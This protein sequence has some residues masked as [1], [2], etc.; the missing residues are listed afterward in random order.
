MRTKIISIVNHKGGVGKTTTAA[1]LG[2]GLVKY[3]KKVL[4][5]DMDPQAGLTTS[6]KINTVSENNSY[7]FF[8][9]KKEI[10]DCIQETEIKNLFI[11]PSTLDLSAAE[12]ELLGQMSFESTLK[13][14][15]KK[16]NGFDYIIIDSPPSL[17]VLTVNCIIAA[18]RLIIPIQC[19]YL[20][21]KALTQLNK[22]IQKAKTINTD[23][24]LKVFFTMY[25]NRTIH[26]E[27]IVQETKKYF[28]AYNT[29]ITRTIKFAYSNVV[30]KPLILF[31]KTSKQS[32]QY[33]DFTKEVLND[34]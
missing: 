9:S 1:N 7:T 13:N 26:S 11:I 6:L 16:E 29:L 34:E 12:I 21:L 14:L 20:S 5:I 25:N 2:A 10:M 27:E 32:K 15:L 33:L 17:G 23:L 28:P 8:M 19:E 18:H 22:I 4:L 31:D 24:K 30:G 3:N